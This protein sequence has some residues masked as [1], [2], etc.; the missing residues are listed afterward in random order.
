ML[1]VLP[2]VGFVALLL[3]FRLR[4][5]GWRSA[6][7]LG[8]TA[9]GILVVLITE[10]L[11]LPRWLARAGLSTAWLSFDVVILIYLWQLVR[12]KERQISVRQLWTRAQ[13]TALK[14]GRVQMGLLAGVTIII[15]SVGVVALVSPPNNWDVMEYHMPR[16]VHWMQNQSIAF[17]PSHTLKQLHMPPWA[18]FAMLHLHVLSGG[19][20]LNNLVQWFGLLGSV[21]AVSLLAQLLGVGYRGQV[22]AATVCAT[23][24]QGILQASGTKNDYVVAFWCVSLTYYLLAFKRQPT[25]LHAFG[26]GGALGLV[27]LTKGTAYVFS[28]ALLLTWFLASP[29]RSKLAWLRCLPLVLL[30]AIGINA[31]HSL[32]NTSL[33][34]S[35]LG[36][37]A[38][39]P[40][41]T[42]KYAND[43]LTAATVVSNTLRNLALHLGTPLRSVNTALEKGVAAITHAVGD[44]VNNP[45]T[46][47]TFTTFHIP[48]MSRHET[49]AGNL[50]HLVLIILTLLMLISR[51]SLRCS[52]DTAIY[53]LGLVFAFV[54]FCALLRW[55]PWNTRIHLPLF[56]LWAA[57]I[58][59]VLV[60]AWPGKITQC[61][62][63]LLLVLALPF[64]FGNQ[65][66][67]LLFGGAVNILS[68]ERNAL[69]FVERKDMLDSYRAVTE[70]IEAQ[71]CQN[72]GLDLSVDF[73]EYPILVLLGADQGTR[74]VKHVSVHNLSARYI[75]AG[76][77]FRP[78]AVI[79]L[80]CAT[81]MEKWK[82]YTASVGPG[83]MFDQIV[84]FRA[85]DSAPTARD[86][87]RQSPPC[88]VT[89]GAGWQALEGDGTFRWRWSEGHGEIRVMTA[90]NRDVVMMGLLRTSQEAHA[91]DLFVNSAKVMTREI[92]QSGGFHP[93]I[94][95]LHLFKLPL[96]LEAGQ[97]SVVLASH[98]PVIRIPPDGRLL[99]FAVW[100]LIFVSADGSALCELQP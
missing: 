48:E 9:W 52:R 79:C 32:R 53:A 88:M 33:Y 21:V 83:T 39:L 10:G 25:W 40:P 50:L 67:S 22:L 60:K 18:E 93:T 86:D 42:F 95:G 5:S 75:G 1:V 70:F 43:E 98:K 51:G 82:T 91:V 29:W 46:T 65:S 97:T 7:I 28:V 14:L 4:G 54:L 87:I 74:S 41:A 16:V 72:V 71:G 19:D 69:Y 68:Q 35:P 20:R 90:G 38:E 61:T 73:F 44:D 17:Y 66:R 24:P 84:V 15:V 77:V 64:V 3:V 62:S 26:M 58:G 34:G 37:G 85:T 12:R 56:V 76:S 2:L 30:L 13:Q 78:C 11:S 99:V 94:P 55:Q 23:I 6:T 80:M 63:V 36:P 81:V 59:V 57:P 27:W 45:H 8:A 31:G 96:Y 49:L 100:N 47:W 89:F 92:T